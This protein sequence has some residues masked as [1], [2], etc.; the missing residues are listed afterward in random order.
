MDNKIQFKI[1]S[2]D[3]LIEPNVSRL[4]T[5]KNEEFI[6]TQVI[7]NNSLHA[8]SSVDPDKL[9]VKISA[10]EIKKIIAD[11][12]N[13]TTNE[14]FKVNK[15]IEENIIDNLKSRFSERK[16]LTRSY[17]DLK[18]FN[19]LYDNSSSTIVKDDITYS[20]LSGNYDLSITYSN[21]SSIQDLGNFEKLMIRLPKKNTTVKF[22]SAHYIINNEIDYISFA[23]CCRKLYSKYP[24]S[25]TIIA[26]PENANI[27]IIEKIV[28]KEFNNTDVTIILYEDKN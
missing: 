22:C 6:I 26:I 3:Y 21:D 10:N 8:F 7:D 24:N 28:N 12:K 16:P 11:K 20:T 17:N 15:T 18:D 4:I 14:Y 23:L 27:P 13:P 19:E 5:H 1:Y 25:K 2:V 9:T